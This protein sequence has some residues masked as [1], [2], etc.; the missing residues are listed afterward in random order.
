MCYYAEWDLRF[1]QATNQI[2]K[3]REQAEKLGSDAKQTFLPA[4][5]AAPQEKV[6]QSSVELDE[7][8][9]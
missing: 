8:T 4:T 1:R 3:S 2:R 9:A 7:L 6:E 5:P